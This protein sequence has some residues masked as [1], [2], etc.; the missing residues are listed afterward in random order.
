MGTIPFVKSKHAVRASSV[1]TGSYVAGTTITSDE[2]N[3]LAILV[4]YTKGDETSM[5]LKLESS[6]D[7]GTTFGQQV[8][9]STSGGTVTPSLAARTF[10]ATGNYWITVNP[11]K[12]DQIKLSVKATGGSPTG[13]CKL[14][15]ITGWV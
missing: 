14:T 2:H 4:E 12:A 6:L 3:Y 10:T 1:L 11:I 8:A 9:E 15:A 7:A 5:E 13:T